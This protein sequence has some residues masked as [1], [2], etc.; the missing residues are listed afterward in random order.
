M[1]PQSTQDPGAPPVLDVAVGWIGEFRFEGR[2]RSGATLQIDG[3]G[4]IATSPMEALLAALGS[5]AGYDVVDILQ[6][7]R[8]PPR[9]MRIQLAG[10]RTSEVPRRFVRIRVEVRIAGEVEPERAER[11][12]TL[13]FEKYCSVRAS[14]DPAIPIEI[15]TVVER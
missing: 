10:E 13:A 8:R 1:Q 2:G 11:A 12:V 5:C 15:T 6:K 14:L 4:N 7:G 9:E 3:D